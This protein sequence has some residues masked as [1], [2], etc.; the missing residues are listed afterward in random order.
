M[1]RLCIILL[2]AAALRAG[3]L[4]VDTSRSNQVRFISV[5]PLES[6]DGVTS[7]ID[8]YI[9]WPGEDITKDSE[10]YFEVDLNTLDTGIGMRNR[11]MRDNYLETDKY[12]IT[13]FT[14]KITQQADSSDGTRI[15]YAEG[16]LF[17]HGIARFKRIKAQVEIT[18]PYWRVHS[19]FSVRLS[20]YDI[21][22]PSVMFMKIN[23]K[24]RLNLDFYLK[25]TNP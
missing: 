4:Q 16:D 22:I 3:E 13:H 5:A 11:H 18:P 10:L 21:E 15:L 1:Y 24:I 17:I 8:G 7:Y 23:D 2:L 19:A 6:F 12:P 9:Y 20:D 25:Q 14:G